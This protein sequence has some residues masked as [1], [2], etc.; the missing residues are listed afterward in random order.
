MENEADLGIKYK[1]TAQQWYQ[2]YGALYVRYIS[3]YK[4]LENC[5]DQQV[6][7]QKQILLKDL[8]ENVMVRLI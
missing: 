3:A 1:R 6:H 4:K 7:P 8:L 5:Y 2:Y